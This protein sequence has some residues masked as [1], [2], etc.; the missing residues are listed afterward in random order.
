MNPLFLAAMFMAQAPAQNVVLVAIDGL[1]P[2]EVFTGGQ[3]SL[4][5]EVENESGLVQRFWRETPEERRRT[6]MPFLW[7]QVAREGQVFGNAARGSP[8]KVTNLRRC[9]YPGYNEMLTGFADPRI[10]N[11]EHPAN[12]NVTVFE[13]LSRQPGLE[14]QVQAFATWDAFFRI[15]NVARSGLDVRAGWVPPFARD[16]D[17]NA[18]R[19]TLDALYRTTTPVFGGN[20]LDAI[21]WAAQ[22]ES[23]R[24]DHPRVLHRA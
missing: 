13:W 2:A 8:A 9:S 15:F 14:G 21:T 7:G 24:T 5:R 3:R 19:D 6:L 23:L 20:A 11:N 16:L 18:T 1:R 22:K 4:M 17:R 12:P 10:L